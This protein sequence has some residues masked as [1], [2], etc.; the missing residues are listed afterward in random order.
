VIT[1]KRLTECTI[2]QGVLAWNRGF[3]GYFFDATTTPE[4]FVT[5]MAMEGLSPDLSIIAF[6]GDEP[7]GIVKN[8]VRLINGYK[9]SWNGGT[10]VAKNYR[11]KGIGKLLIEKSLSIYQEEGVDVATLEAISQNESAIKLYEKFG[12]ET[13]DHIEMLSL[14]GPSKKSIRQLPN[15]EIIKTIP[16]EIGGIPFYKAM[17]PWQTHW[18]NAR[19]GEAIIVLDEFGEIAGYAYFKRMI[20]D[21]FKH[22][23]TSIFQCEANPLRKDALEITEFLLAS[24]YFDFSDDIRR[25]VLNVPTNRSKLTY[26]VLKDFGFETTV[27]QVYMTKKLK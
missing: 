20:N 9:V 6:D 12:Y 15:F 7:I 24:I 19:D 25:T 5:R 1:I 23:S 21:E 22:I 26:Q 10:G 3:E 13:T 4:R 17:N 11:S 2:E 18:R 16:Q 27:Q 8:G 14:N